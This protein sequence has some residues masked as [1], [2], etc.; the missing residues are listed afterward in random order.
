MKY[1]I[2]GI[3]SLILLC[4]SIQGSAADLGSSSDNA[5]AYVKLQISYEDNQGNSVNLIC[6][7][8]LIASDLVITASHCIPDAWTQARSKALIFNYGKGF[9]TTARLHDGMAWAK[10]DPV[11]DLALVRMDRRIN[12]DSGAAL[13]ALDAACPG[14]PRLDYPFDAI[15]YQRMNDS[16]TPLRRGG[17]QTTRGTV[18]GYG[19]SVLA[20]GYSYISN[21]VGGPGDSGSSVYSTDG[22]LIGVYNGEGGN[23]S[24]A[25]ALCLYRDQIDA[26]SDR[27]HR[28]D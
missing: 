11:V 24:Y 23:H 5:A 16:D 3:T 10:F 25:A 14:G 21:R 9:A 19:R 8:T 20:N 2:I 12:R 4:A 6:G 7:G 15:Y 26:K 13:A 27:L 17:Y 18:S 22:V 28:T 1:L